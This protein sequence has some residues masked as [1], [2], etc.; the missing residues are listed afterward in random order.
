MIQL[1]SIHTL[2]KK[3]TFL[4]LFNSFETIQIRN[5]VFILWFLVTLFNLNKA[6]HIDDTFHLEAGL[7]VIKKFTQPM[8]VSVIWDTFPTPLY[9]GNQPPL[10]FYLVGIFQLIS[11]SSEIVLH[12]MLSF[13]TYLAILFFYKL[14]QLFSAKHKPTILT[15]FAFCPAFI[16]N[17]NV[18]IDVP[19]LALSLGSMYFLIKGLEEKEYKYLLYSSIYFSIGILFK[20]SI[21]PLFFVIALSIIANKQFKNLRVLL[22]PFGVLT[23]WS[24]WN[25]SEFGFIH[26]LARGD[27][28]S[29]FDV[30]KLLSFCNAMGSISF[31]SILFLTDLLPKSIGKFLTV[32]F[33]TGLLL[34]VPLVYLGYVEQH[35]TDK[36][37]NYLFIFNGGLIMVFC[38]V[39]VGK[40]FYRNRI[41]TIHSKY[42]PVILFIVGLS[43]FFILFAPYMATRHVLLILPF[44]LLLGH[45]QFEKSKGLVNSLVLIFSVL[46]GTLLGISDWHY[47]EFYRK[48]ANT[49]KVGAEKYYSIGH[50]GWQWYTKKAGMINYS[51]PSEVKIRT[52]DK[53]VI[54]NG[55]YKQRL[56]NRIKLD[57]I[58]VL[59]EPASL[60]TFF[61]GNNY[62]S[63]YA[64]A[65]NQPPWTL[66]KA[67]IDTVYVCK[68]KKELDK[69]DLMYQMKA[70]KVWLDFLLKQAKYQDL[71]ADSIV[72][73]EADNILFLTRGN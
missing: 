38:L 29:E 60:A 49:F 26:I 1:P 53:I 19:L 61:S 22:V 5:V 34:V 24:I 70:D 3:R 25:L 65:W 9:T 57:T 27:S 67:S 11:G 12:L 73:L 36:Y 62:A 47:A 23:L 43:V 42:L 54:A 69:E 39:L 15:I 4:F 51:A 63:M 66:S 33:F 28:N 68:V 52:N 32:T 46:L 31:I 10:F 13:F 58:T 41:K 21:T 17:Q 6:F 56:N 30:L 71:P 55:T 44:I 64:S 59:T 20:Y 48:T 45:K 14:L 37:L 8:S 18:M 72:S 40:L 2:T 35:I 16:I 50:W 7:G